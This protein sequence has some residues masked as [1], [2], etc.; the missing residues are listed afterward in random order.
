MHQEHQA[1]QKKKLIHAYK[2]ERRNTWS[3]DMKNIGRNVYECSICDMPF[4]IIDYSSNF[5]NMHCIQRIKIEKCIKMFAKVLQKQKS[6][7]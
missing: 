4:D 7:S 1:R 5:Q 6:N 3:K 2:R